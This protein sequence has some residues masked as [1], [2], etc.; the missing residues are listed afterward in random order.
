ME[1]EELKDTDI[2]AEMLRNLKL[3]KSL[4]TVNYKMANC[5]L[6]NSLHA[7]SAVIEADIHWHMVKIMA[8]EILNNKSASIKKSRDLFDTKYEL[9]M[10]A[11]NLAEFKDIVHTVLKKLTPTQINQIRNGE[12]ETV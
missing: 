7:S 10:I 1:I 6:D 11:V 9:Q 8:T 5:I 3:A 12:T 2:L 4:H